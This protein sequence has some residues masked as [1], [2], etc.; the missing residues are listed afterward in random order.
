M[1]RTFPQS[2]TSR[3]WCH[4]PRDGEPVTCPPAGGHTGNGIRI[5]CPVYLD[6]VTVENFAENGI[7]VSAGDDDETVDPGNA[8]GFQITA[9]R[10]GGN[11]KNGIR[12]HGRDATVGLVSCCSAGNNHGWGFR[13]DTV[14][15]TT[16]VACHGEANRGFGIDGNFDEWCEYSTSG[17]ANSSMFLSCYCE[18]RI[19]ELGFA[20]QCIGGPLSQ[21]SFQ[22]HQDGSQAVSANIGRRAVSGMPLSFANTTGTDDTLV[23]FGQRWDG[24]DGAVF[25]FAV[26]GFTDYNIL[27]WDAASGW[28][29]INNS[30][31]NGRVSIQLPYDG[32]RSTAR[33]AGVRKRHLLRN[34]NGE[35]CRGSIQISHQPF[36]RTRCSD[37]RHLRS[38][39]HRL[40]QYRDS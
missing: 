24:F 34:C 26:P 14:V 17:V 16:Y 7:Y 25:N 3:F 19:N 37:G 32:R 18:G 13:D 1:A 30:S 8:G 27:R 35:D 20:V 4:E 22:L 9:C 5:N 10:V 33:C 2:D 38:F 11:G 23:E 36:F 39:G 21:I 29:Q 40:E 31:P 28:W 12:I 15:G 6:H